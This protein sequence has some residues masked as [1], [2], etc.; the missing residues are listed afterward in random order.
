M[1]DIYISARQVCEKAEISE[2]TLR[3]W[4]KQKH[5]SPPEKINGKTLGWKLSYLKSHKWL[6]HRDN[7]YAH[8]QE[9]NKLKPRV[10][11]SR[12]STH[13]GYPVNC[14]IKKPSFHRILDKIVTDI[15]NSLK[16]CKQP[17]G[18]AITLYTAHKKA[19]NQI[20]RLKQRLGKQIGIN[21]SAITHFRKNEN[22]KEN[23]EHVHL[24]L[25]FDANKSPLGKIQ[26]RRVICEIVE[27]MGQGQCHMDFS[28]KEGRK[29]IHFMMTQ[30]HKDSFVYHA[31]YLAKVRT[32]AKSRRPFS[33]SR[34]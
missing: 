5:I 11:I 30:E 12:K 24:I 19:T 26:I 27:R 16:E 18:V 1:S 28:H 10:A 14:G 34:T 25:M 7:E 8:I 3:N 31:S 4:V 9:S 23:G 13:K 33:C 15:D 20:Y 6:Q 22:G 32:T 29:G 21:P 17:V 2:R